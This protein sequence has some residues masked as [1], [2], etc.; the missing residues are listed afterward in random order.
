MTVKLKIMVDDAREITTEQA[1]VYQTTGKKKKT[2]K[3]TKKATKTA[4]SADGTEKVAADPKL[5][6][7]LE[8]SENEKVLRSLKQTL[9][10]NSGG[11]EVVLVLGDQ[12][13]KRAV[14]L[15]GRVS[16][17]ETVLTGLRELV[18]A[19]NVKLH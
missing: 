7:R 3:T 6:I 17:D 15:P 1:T 11:T 13:N 16:T 9:D 12:Q 10:G 19:D 4:K 5:Y 14:K 8:T 2:P 18:G